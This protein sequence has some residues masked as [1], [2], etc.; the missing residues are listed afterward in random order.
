MA[1]NK[2]A[3]QEFIATPVDPNSELKSI[4][5]KPGIIGLDYYED[6]LSPTIT[7]KVLFSATEIVTQNGS[8][9][10][11][12]VGGETI[13]FDITVPDFENLNIEN[14]VIRSISG[15]KTGRQGLYVLELVSKESV[16]NETTRIVKK[17][18]KNISE[19]VK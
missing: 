17:F 13:S 5:L 18:N 9:E 12:L 8:E 11:K 3:I 4:N 1:E 16:T 14:M 19:I 7:A 2:Y 10:V 6:I 15:D